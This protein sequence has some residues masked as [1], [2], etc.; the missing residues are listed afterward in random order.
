M[1]KEDNISTLLT[2]LCH[3]KLTEE[4]SASLF[5]RFSGV[6]PKEDEITEFYRSEW[7][8]TTT[9]GGKLP[10]AEE[11]WEKTAH[12]L[13]ICSEQTK[14]RMIIPEKLSFL[15]YAAIFIV[16]FVSAWMLHE[17]VP[18]RNA[19]G[20]KEPHHTAVSV[21]NGSKTEIQLPDGSVVKLNSGST[22]TYP[23]AFE[24]NNRIVKLEGEGFFTVHKDPARP[25]YVNT[26]NISVKVLGTVFNVKSYPDE[27][28]IETTLL[29]GSVEIYGESKSTGNSSDE[30]PAAVLNPNERAIW[31]KDGQEKSGEFQQANLVIERLDDAATS[32]AW[33]DNILKFDNEKFGSIIRKLER[34][35]GVEIESRY[36]GLIN[37]RFSGQF[38]LETV[39]QALN[40]MTFTEPFSFSINKNKVTIYKK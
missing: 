32:I 5:A 40:A 22:L 20:Y 13:G 29:S 35:Y 25:F 38:D 37:E 3:N 17:I 28:L 23:S 27:N 1:E 24:S 14:R 12:R 31:Y 19:A 7:E 8:K 11:L 21:P 16:A 30:Q 15:K 10:Q 4:Q 9:A 26:T 6:D 34:W 18:G 36:Q 33:K 39:E 2:G